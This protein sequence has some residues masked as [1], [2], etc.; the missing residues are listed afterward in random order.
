[1]PWESVSRSYLKGCD[2]HT[3]SIKAHASCSS[4]KRR[5][6]DLASLIYSGAGDENSGRGVL[7]VG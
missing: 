4:A 6:L 2:E 3:S 5:Y 7:A 1:M